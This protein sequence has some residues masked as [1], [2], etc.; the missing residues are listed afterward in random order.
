M[1]HY[2]IYTIHYYSVMHRIVYEMLIWLHFTV[3]TQLIN[4]L[5]Q[6]YKSTSSGLQSWAVKCSIIWL[7]TV[8]VKP[9]D[10]TGCFVVWNPVTSECLQVWSQKKQTKKTKKITNIYN[11]NITVQ[12]QETMQMFWFPLVKMDSYNVSVHCI[13]HAC[14]IYM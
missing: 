4:I 13:V 8:S 6:N 12:D 5:S 9:C 2:C 11:G 14:K 7:E 10:L 1:Q 3:P